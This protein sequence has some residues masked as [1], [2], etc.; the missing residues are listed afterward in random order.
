MQQYDNI[1]KIK[2]SNVIQDP[3]FVREVLSY[4]IGGK[5]MPSSRANYAKVYI[6]DEYWGLYVNVE[7]VDKDMLSGHYSSNDN[8][9]VKCNPASL[10][11]NGE[12]SN[13]GS[14]PGTDTT[15]YFPFSEHR[16]C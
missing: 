7:S 6:N 13:L 14:H 5:Y 8:T 12:N 4:D 15:A 2:L 9:L 11:V 16:G 1:D 3:S 10:D